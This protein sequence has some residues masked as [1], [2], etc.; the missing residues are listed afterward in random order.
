MC[1]WLVKSSLKH[2][3]SFEQMRDYGEASGAHAVIGAVFAR[4]NAQ[5]LKEVIP[6]DAFIPKL[7]VLNL[8]TR[9]KPILEKRR[10]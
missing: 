8:K 1:V 4:V 10:P 7:I 2:V 3:A 5:G 9:T 6:P